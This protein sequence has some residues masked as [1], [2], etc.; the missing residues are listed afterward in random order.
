MHLNQIAL[1]GQDAKLYS[2]HCIKVTKVKEKAIYYVSN[3]VL[4]RSN[5]MWDIKTSVIFTFLFSPNI[6]E[7]SRQLY[8]IKTDL[9]DIDKG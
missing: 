3:T 4:S 7:T 1:R 9:N 2:G 6:K 8:L 5:F